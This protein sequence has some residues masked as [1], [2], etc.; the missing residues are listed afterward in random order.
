MTGSPSVPTLFVTAT[1]TEVGKTAVAAALAAL[2]RQRGRDV[3]VLKPVSSG[4]A[5]VDGKLVSPDG[6]CLARAAGADD[7]HEL[8]CPVRL[9]HPLAPSVAAELESCEI[10][11][12][13]VW[14]AVST[15]SGRHDRLIVE[16]IGGIA[17]PITATYSV[18]DMAV[19]LGA[20]LLVVG[21]AGLGTI[22]HS[23]LTVEYARSRGLEVAAV[24]LN[25]PRDL[26]AGIAEETNASVI[27]RLSGVPVLGPLRHCHGVSTE[28]GELG[29]LPAMLA[30][31]DDVDKLIAD[32]LGA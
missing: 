31:L 25:S 26:P 18:A 10:D 1:D 2:L 27:A 29:E 20:P 24:L 30:G 12:S 16:G 14:D 5:E 15:L 19:E 22:N 11:L 6:L 9:R 21:R 3:G 28:T 4:C 32:Y 23:L 17:V 8:V 7:P 13:A